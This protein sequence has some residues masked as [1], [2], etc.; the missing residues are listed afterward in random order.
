MKLFK[1]LNYLL[2]AMFV[3]SV[4]VQ[5]NDPDPLVW[6]TVYGLAAVACV[7]A[8]KR[9]THWLLPGGLALLT[10]IWAS[11]L[12]LRVWGRVAIGE[13]F[14]AWEMKDQRVEEAR[15]L[16]GLLI[17]AV[18]MLVL[19]GRAVRLWLTRRAPAKQN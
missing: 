13:L 4:L 9:P 15:E 12:A 19:F 3:F 7:L 6:L 18:W 2:L 8:F 17:V 10:L 1:L 16:G 11:T 14:E 5:Y